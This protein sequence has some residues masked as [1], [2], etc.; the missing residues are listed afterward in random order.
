MIKKSVFGRKFKKSLEK[1]I[2]CR[3]VEIKRILHTTEINETIQKISKINHQKPVFGRKFKK[4]MEKIVFCR[5]VEIKRT[6]HTI[7]INEKYLKSQNQKSQK[8]TK[9]RKIN[10]LFYFCLIG[11]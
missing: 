2:F 7:E 9:N 10:N 11:I 8:I 3:K 4:S 6:L 1:I 5:K